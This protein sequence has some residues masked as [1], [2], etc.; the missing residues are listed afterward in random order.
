ME[1]NRD[2]IT[3]LIGVIEAGDPMS[4][5][6][7]CFLPP[8]I[9]A[10]QAFMEYIEFLSKCNHSSN[11]LLGKIC[12]DFLSSHAPVF[13]RL[14]SNDGKENEKFVELD[15]M[16][17]IGKWLDIACKI[18]ADETLVTWNEWD[19]A[20][21]L[22]VGAGFG[23][24]N[25]AMLLQ[26][27]L[28]GCAADMLVRIPPVNI[29]AI[30]DGIRVQKAIC[31]LNLTAKA[32]RDSCRL[33]VVTLTCN[34]IKKRP[35]IEILRRVAVARGLSDGGV[36]W[37]RDASGFFGWVE[38]K[39]SLDDDVPVSAYTPILHK[40]RS[41]QVTTSKAV[42]SQENLKSDML[43]ALG[44]D[45]PPSRPVPMD[46]HRKMAQ[47]ISELSC[48]EMESLILESNEFNPFNEDDVRPVPTSRKT[49]KN[50]YAVST[51][52]L[53]VMASSAV[54][55]GARDTFSLL[56]KGLR[57]LK[58]PGGDAAWDTMHTAFPWMARANMLLSEATEIASRSEDGLMRL[59]PILLVGPP[60]TG[61]SRW[62]RMAAEACGLPFYP[63]PF[64][65]AN[66]SVLVNGTERGWSAARAGLAALAMRDTDC[67]NP[68]VLVDEVDKSGKG[69][70]NGNPVMAL[71][72]L[73]ERE[74]S[75]AFMD[76]YL[77][78]TIDA[79]GI[80]WVLTANS[81]E[82][83]P[84]PLLNRVDL[85]QVV[86]PPASCMRGV[87]SS[88]CADLR[89]QWKMPLEAMPVLD[90][91]DIQ[92]LLHTYSKNQDMRSLQARLAATLRAKVWSP[93]IR[94]LH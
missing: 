91:M 83:L 11:K 29:K 68:M 84:P 73:L 79:S 47:L 66:T 87:L 85:V 88:M 59:R 63:V 42:G 38:L 64:A 77:L 78:T 9:P 12:N 76:S 71:L 69:D 80:N 86:A 23:I 37:F 39:M 56:R 82:H 25:H 43:V 89:M 1:Q 54:S 45:S 31:C 14:S 13:A 5:A 67:A 65:G 70:Q 51:P 62:A 50:R 15:D 41:R 30:N 10:V 18:L 53:S 26:D 3:N 44:M 90:E 19:Q 24:K 4:M 2:F 46:E 35:D 28:N 27:I 33:Q 52:R 48:V 16:E 55:D 93:P 81:I 17:F 61:K 20:A 57:T 92:K 72:P 49:R 7:P 94:A 6:S 58:G 21:F 74:T 40:R 32:W 8:N 36:L 22:R 34:D 75:V 60:G